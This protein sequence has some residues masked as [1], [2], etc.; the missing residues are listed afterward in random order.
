MCIMPVLRESE[1]QPKTDLRLGFLR[2]NQ[3][4]IT[5]DTGS[6]A[7]GW[8]SSNLFLAP[9]GVPETIVMSLTI[10][11]AKPNPIGKDRTP[12]GSVRPE[13]LLGEWADIKNVGSSSI[14]ISTLHLSHTR[15]SDSC[16]PSGVEEY[17]RG[18][19]NDFLQPGKGLSKNNIFKSLACTRSGS[20]RGRSSRPPF[21]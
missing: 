17:W 6:L 19:G 10:H 9:K 20:C 1:A 5:C 11:Q 7:H 4:L 21:L 2:T 3:W 12:T 8:S 16:Q 18:G 15:F 13:Q 14:R